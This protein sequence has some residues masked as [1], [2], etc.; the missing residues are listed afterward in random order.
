MV[1]PPPFKVGAAP[2]RRRVANGST[3]SPHDE[4]FELISRH[5]TIAD[6]LSRSF[7]SAEASLIRR[8][9]TRS[10][11]LGSEWW[12]GGGAMYG[13]SSDADGDDIVR[14]QSVF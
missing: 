10:V 4:C 1:T 12:R 5:Q 6:E 2:R 13:R 8:L 7:A 11:R 3:P 9:R 14:A